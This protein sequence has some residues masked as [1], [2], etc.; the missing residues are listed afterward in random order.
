MSWQP[1][2]IM[3]TKS[4]DR[5]TGVCGLLPSF[6]CLTS[7]YCRPDRDLPLPAYGDVKCRPGPRLTPEVRVELLREKGEI[8]VQ[9]KQLHT[10][11]ECQIT[12]AEPGTQREHVDQPELRAAVKSIP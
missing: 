11:S 3:S 6:M 9:D 5:D 10:G 2:R 1:A 8:Y 12:L 4:I 7:L